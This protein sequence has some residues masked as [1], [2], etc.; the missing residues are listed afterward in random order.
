VSKAFAHDSFMQEVTLYAARLAHA[1]SPRSLAVIKRQ[2]WES[3]FQDLGEAVEIA[4]REMF[5]S[6]ESADFKEGIAHFIEKRPPR[7]TGA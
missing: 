4:D 1:V 2:L 3:L 5:A 7:F 6:F